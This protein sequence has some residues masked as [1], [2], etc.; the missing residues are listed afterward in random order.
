MIEKF[1]IIGLYVSSFI[2]ISAISGCEV[3]VDFGLKSSTFE[4]Y[5]SR[6]PGNELNM[7]TLMLPGYQPDNP[8]FRYI[9]KYF[10]ND[11]CTGE[12]YAGDT[13]QYTVEGTWTLP[14]PDV[15]RMNLDQFV[16]ADFKITKLD[17]VTYLLKSE[18][19]A[20]GLPIEPPTTP[21][22]MYNRKLH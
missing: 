3:F 21:L 11:R 12:Y 4:L 9:V 7:L 19:N 16:D 18:A 17:K 1:K 10:D 13:L 5:E 22:H 15:L 8:D 2:L 20:H 14:E 6:I